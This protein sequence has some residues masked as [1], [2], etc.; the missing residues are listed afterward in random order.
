MA[1]ISIF[2]EEGSTNIDQN[3]SVSCFL[4]SVSAVKPSSITLGFKKPVSLI[5][6]LSQANEANRPGDLVA[7]LSCSVKS[8]VFA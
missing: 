4:I 2:S 3:A 7:M 6:F 5:D 1:V 8:K